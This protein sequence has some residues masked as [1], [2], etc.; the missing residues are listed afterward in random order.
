MKL[1]HPTALLVLLGSA[2]AVVLAQGCNASTAAGALTMTTLA[3]GASAARRAS[4]ECDVEC[5]PGTQC[6]LPTGL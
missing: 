3:G 1:R 5:R 6:N 4:G 2:A